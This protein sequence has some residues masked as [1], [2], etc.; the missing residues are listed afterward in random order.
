MK[1]ILHTIY[2]CLLWMGFVCFA[3]SGCK[4]DELVKNNGEVVEG[5]PITV[6]M[7]L[8]GTPAADVTVDTRASDNDLSTLS[9]LTIYVFDGNGKYQQTVSTLDG[10]LERVS[11]PTGATDVTYEVKFSTTSGTK[12]LL[13]VGNSTSSVWSE[14]NNINVYTMNFEEL[15]KHL[16]NLNIPLNQDGEFSWNC[17]K[18]G[19]K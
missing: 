15:K 13:A 9:N 1:K 4:D 18:Q 12:K 19:R 16:A 14:A 5:V 8:A 2:T 11:G 7:K 10:T 17:C 6:T 3:L